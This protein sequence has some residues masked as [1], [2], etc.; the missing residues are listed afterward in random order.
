M[1][2]SREEAF[3][4]FLRAV[5]KR[6]NVLPSEVTAQPPSDGD[7]LLLSAILHHEVD[8][9][10][11][12]PDKGEG[13]AG[14]LEFIAGTAFALWWSIRAEEEEDVGVEVE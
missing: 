11:L 6:L 4:E 3:S 13:G 12:L 5:Q 14:I 10:I 7:A 1:K 2:Q 9:F 8:D